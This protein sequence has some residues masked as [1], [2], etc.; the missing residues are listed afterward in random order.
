MDLNVTMKCKV[1]RYIT[2][3]VRKPSKI[4]A[5]ASLS[6]HINTQIHRHRQADRHTHKGRERERETETHTHR[7][8]ETETETQRERQRQS[9]RE[10]EIQSMVILN[11]IG[12][13]IKFNILNISNSLINIPHFKDT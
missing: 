2:P 8:R 5:T 1:P 10:R 11:P 3:Q 4:N 12:G 6:P 7:E 9:N 13:T